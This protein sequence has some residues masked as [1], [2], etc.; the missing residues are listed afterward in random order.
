MT[1]T[2]RFKTGILILTLFIIFIIIN[3]VLSTPLQISNVKIEQIDKNTVEINWTTNKDTF[4]GVHI[5]EAESV[6]EILRNVFSCNN[7]GDL[8]IK[9]SIEDT[10]I[11]YGCIY[12]K[13]ADG[14][15]QLVHN[16]IAYGACTV[17]SRF[18]LCTSANF[19]LSTQHS[20]IVNV[21]QPNTE[22]EFIIQ[23]NFEPPTGRDRYSEKL[24]NFKML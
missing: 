23:A 12:S 13:D 7:T 10:F 11:K 19:S 21:L 17:D 9:Q 20:V 24:V 14:F 8:I 3:R 5:E 18:F 15:P 22:Y 6:N 4:G 1:K 16:G 2:S